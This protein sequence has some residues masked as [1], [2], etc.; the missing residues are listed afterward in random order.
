[1]EIACDESGSEGEKLV[2][3]VTAVFAHAS[4]RLDPADAAA[5]LAELRDRI[6]SPALEYKANHLL[7][8]KHRPTLLWLLGPAG[9]VLGHAYVQLVDKRAFLLHHLG[10]TPPGPLEPYNDAL[11]ARGPHG[12]LDPLF[13][14]I[15]RA[16]RH[17]GDDVTVRHDFHPTLTASRIARLHD[18]APGLRELTLVDSRADH[19]VQVADFV[20][21]VARRIA[22]EE[23]RGHPDPEVARLL[24][25]YVIGVR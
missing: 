5:C 25:P 6:R 1:M 4:V 12:S 14:A 22:E 16:V 21:G 23:S 11:R 13:P 15:V 8:P 2:G 18:A 24:R 20:A 7:R 17:W 10:H 19:R 9:P 3:G